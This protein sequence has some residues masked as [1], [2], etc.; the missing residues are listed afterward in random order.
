VDSENIELV[1]TEPT[2]IF[3]A[4]SLLLRDERLYARM[5]RPSFPFGNGGAGP[6]IAEL[7]EDFLLPEPSQLAPLTLIGS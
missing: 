7:I 4:V 3:E 1:G 6:R 2:R 5:A